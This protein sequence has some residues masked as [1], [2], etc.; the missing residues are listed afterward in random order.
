MVSVIKFFFILKSSGVSVEKEGEWL[1]SNIQGF[2]FSS[3]M[4]SNPNISKHI[5]LSV[6]SG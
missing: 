3:K 2:S 1:T 6:S 4:M 5:E